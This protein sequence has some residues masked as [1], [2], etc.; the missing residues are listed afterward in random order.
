M[1]RGPQPALAFVIRCQDI[2]RQ[3]IRSEHARFHRFPPKRNSSINLNFDRKKISA[4]G[5]DVRCMIMSVAALLGIHTSTRI[6][7]LRLSRSLRRVPTADEGVSE[8]TCTNLRAVFRRLTTWRYSKETIRVK[9]LR[10]RRMFHG[11]PIL[12]HPLRTTNNPIS[13]T[14]IILPDDFTIPRFQIANIV[15]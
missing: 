4:D 2:Q 14:P 8:M 7:H 10:P 6:K 3:H 12:M 11:P 9:F 15:F 5:C 1:A 13:R